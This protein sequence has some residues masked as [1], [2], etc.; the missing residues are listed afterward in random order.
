[1]N[2]I[3]MQHNLQSLNERRSKIFS[4]EQI[5]KSN[6]LLKSGKK[7]TG[8]IGD[9]D[10]GTDLATQEVALI[11]TCIESLEL[12]KIDAALERLRAG[13]YGICEVCGEQI[14]EKRLALTPE[15]A[16]CTDCAPLPNK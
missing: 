15:A 14:A 8:D 5:E 1:M 12:A 2:K 16:Y 4:L 3:Q 11:L 13:T 7:A 9:T 6:A 10:L